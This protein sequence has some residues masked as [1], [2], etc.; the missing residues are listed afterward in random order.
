[1]YG[2]IARAVA[3]DRP[4]TPWPPSTRPAGQ[5]WG[6]ERELAEQLPVDSRQGR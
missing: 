5:S 2:T 1:M 3:N 6:L 4:A